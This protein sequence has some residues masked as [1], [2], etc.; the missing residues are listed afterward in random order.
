MPAD[1][2]LRFR[3]GINVGDIIIDGDD[4]FGDGVNVAARLQALAEPGGICV[5]RAVRDQVLDKLSSAFEDLGQR[6]V[7]NMARSIH[8]YRVELDPTAVQPHEGAPS[9]KPRRSRPRAA[10]PWLVA[11][12]VGVIGIGV[13]TWATHRFIYAPSA[14]APYSAE[15]R[16]M[17]FAIIPL[18]APAADPAAVQVAATVTDRTLAIFEEDPLWFQVASRR[19]VE[20]ASTRHAAL[21]DLAA[22]LDVHFLVRGNV[23][24]ASAGYNV[25]L[26][27]VDGRT[28]RVVDKGSLVVGQG[29]LTPR[30][31]WELGRVANDLGYKALVLEVQRARSKPDTALDVRDLS[32]RALVEWEDRKKQQDEEGAYTAATTLLNRA[33]ALSPD[34]RLALHLTATVNLCDCVEGWSRNIA[35]QHAIGEAALEKALRHDPRSTWMLLIKSDLL[36]WQGKFEESLLLVES[37]LARDPD[38]SAA[39]GQKAYALLKLGKPREAATAIEDLM[40]PAG[41][42]PDMP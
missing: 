14:P 20:E 8:V 11:I 32:F 17:T 34:D 28:E 33:L 29:P 2:Q 31:R 40:S 3:V 1:D 4:I 5:S 39:M 6:D 13:A 38:N 16:R 35:E 19:R 30:L 12:L 25:E 22:A 41:I 37:I 27:L 21:K 9:T 36:A 26:M 42:R 18:T 23:T 15:D 24:P 10:R 7:K